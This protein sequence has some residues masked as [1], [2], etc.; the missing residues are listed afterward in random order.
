MKVIVT[1]TKHQSVGKYAEN[2]NISE[3]N[4]AAGNNINPQ[5]CFFSVSL[6]NLIVLHRLNSIL[7][8]FEQVHFRAVSDLLVLRWQ[9]ALFRLEMVC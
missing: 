9:C 7:P 2:L 8:F 1:F 6:S 4:I 3:F 5:S